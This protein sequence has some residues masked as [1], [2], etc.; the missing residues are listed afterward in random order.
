MLK[1]ESQA[2][3]AISSTDAKAL[4]LLQILCAVPYWRHKLCESVTASKAKLKF[5]ESK[6]MKNRSRKISRIFAFASLKPSGFPW[7]S[8]H[9]M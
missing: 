8:S 1:V 4:S 2:I 6:T 3:R 5:A 7:Y 9:D